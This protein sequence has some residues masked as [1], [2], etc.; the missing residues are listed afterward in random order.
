[1]KMMV[2]MYTQPQATT[3]EL[4]FLYEFDS[5]VWLHDIEGRW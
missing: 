4:Y 5:F 3:G 1:M 2:L